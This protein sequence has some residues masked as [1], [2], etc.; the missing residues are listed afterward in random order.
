VARPRVFI[1]STFY[2]LKYVRA[3]LEKFIQGMGFDPVLH[4]RGSVAYGTAERLEQYCYREVGLADMV[5]HIVGGRFGS[6]SL[7][8]EHSSV[9]QMELRAAVKQNKQ[10][11]IC[12]D[13]QVWGDYRHYLRNKDKGFTGLTYEV[14]ED[15]RV[16]KFIEEV[17][18]LPKNNQI[19]QFES[20]DRIIEH[21]R[22]QWAGL[23]QRFLQE[24]ESLPDRRIAEDMENTLKTLNDV[25]T[26][27]TKA[28]KDQG[29]ALK[30]IL[31]SNHPMFAR[32]KKLT[33]TQYRVFF[34]DRKEMETWLSARTWRPINEFEWDDNS[35]A[36]YM[37][38][39]KTTP[40]K[41]W[42]LKV[43]L[44]V[45]D[46]AGRL[47]AIASEDWKDEWVSRE[48]ILPKVEVDFEDFRG[49]LEA[50]DDDLPF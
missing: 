13:Q 10:L 37:Q 33:W 29:A 44:S 24:Q 18:N 22:E 27:L 14:A 49:A 17:E 2:D 42:V 48:E 36:E 50:D 3:D 31:L 43:A 9:S 15:E 12:I 16:L 38:D 23:F 40:G 11:Y 8:D 21:L 28:S 46:D 34:R 41:K 45:F 7:V 6:K 47:R 30:E 25:V 26:Y 19:I 39:D 35:V 4:E 5:V 1:S 20:S 32:I